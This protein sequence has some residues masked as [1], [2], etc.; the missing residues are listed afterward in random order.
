MEQ[1]QEQAVKL[2]FCQDEASGETKTP[3][4]LSPDTQPARKEFVSSYRAKQPCMDCE[5]G[6]LAVGISRVSL[7]RASP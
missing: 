1:K 6:H 7:L 5:C 4:L 3:P 2:C